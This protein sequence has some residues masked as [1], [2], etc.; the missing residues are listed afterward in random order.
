MR[1][2]DPALWENE[3]LVLCLFSNV[4]SHE[5]FRM[6]IEIDVTVMEQQFDKYIRA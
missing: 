3:T 1:R 2:Y 5:F 4:K 6:L